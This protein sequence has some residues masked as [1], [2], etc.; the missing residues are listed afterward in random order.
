M[1]ARLT[2]ALLMVAAAAQVSTV[3][4]DALPD[5]AGGSPEMLQTSPLG[6][7]LEDV[8]DWSTSYN[9]V[10]VMKQS[11]SWITQNAASNIFDTEDAACLDLDERG[12]VR[13][14]TPQT[15]RP[16]C[17]SPNY[18]S[19]ATLFFFGEWKGHYPAGRYQVTYNGRGK[20]S[21]FFAAR[22]A[23]SLPNRDEVDVDPSLGGWMM[24]IEE[25]DPT[26]PIR[27][28][29]VYMPGYGISGETEF[30]PDFLKQ[31]RNVKIVRFMDWMKTNNSTQKE[32]ADRPKLD[33]VRW[34]E[35]G[36]PLE[37]MLRLASREMLSP[38]FNMPHEASDDYVRQF[39]TMVQRDL[40]GP[41]KVYVEYS[42]EVWNGQF[43][44]GQYVE[45]RGT[46]E[47]GASQGTAFDRRLNWYGQRSAQICDIWK[48]VFASEP[49]RVV[50]VLG[51]QAANDYTQTQA[52]DCPMW[53]SGKPCSAHGMKAVA[54]A[55]YF[56]GYLG[57]P[58]NAA[59]V[60]DWSL[61]TL[62]AEINNG[63]Q[64]PN[65]PRGGALAQ[66]KSWIGPHRVAANARGL[67]L[68]AY[69]GGQHL[70][71]F[72]GAEN[73]PALTALFTSANRDP[74]MEQAYGRYLQ[75]WRDK[76]GQTFIHFNA[77]GQYSKYGSWGTVEYL[78]EVFLSPKAMALQNFALDGCWWTGC[79]DW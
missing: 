71:G 7:N 56:G 79:S 16:G 63:G 34:T 64:L 57:K 66:A 21:Y 25:I 43:R 9:F 74:R 48:Q 13:S 4:A 35:R 29:H 19:V 51:A 32:F 61:D 31:L 44:Q 20:L 8:Q 59:I 72:N 77:S 23:N 41:Q 69:E 58:G 24:R 38:W 10:D 30:H 68:I 2:A 73:I 50:C 27:D 6:Q 62:F 26:D 3:H 17:T 45:D 65:G 14:L 12:Y 39:A 53:T 5:P 11:R 33:D 1:V 67:Q 36:V 70:V 18:D 60:K 49:N 28:I 15:D 40:R 55:P 47:Y 46:A 37:Q 75:N 76:G 52:A 54:I 42:N 22:K 78:D